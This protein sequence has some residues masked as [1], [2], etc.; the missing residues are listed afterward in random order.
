[1]VG[2]RQGPGLRGHSFSLQVHPGLNRG[3]KQLQALV[4]GG[5]EALHT[6]FQMTAQL[7]AVRLCKSKCTLGQARP[8]TPMHTS[9]SDIYHEFHPDE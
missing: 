4:L 9:R 6:W 1:M 2:L 5:M 7:C 3:W 8:P